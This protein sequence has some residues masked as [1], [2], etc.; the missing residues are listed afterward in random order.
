MIQWL[1][2]SQSVSASRDISGINIH[3]PCPKLHPEPPW[4]HSVIK[5]AASIAPNKATLAL[6]RAWWCI[7]WLEVLICY[8]IRPHRSTVMANI[9]CRCQCSFFC[10][11]WLVL[12]VT[13]YVIVG[14][15]SRQLLW[16]W[17]QT[18]MFFFPLVELGEDKRNLFWR[19]SSANMCSDKQHHNYLYILREIYSKLRFQIMGEG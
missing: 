7:Y 17:R 19:K 18:T 13:S 10:S 5:G 1:H 15:S 16:D 6:E 11:A 2:S 8:T 14:L 3:L 12:W 9:M 4:S